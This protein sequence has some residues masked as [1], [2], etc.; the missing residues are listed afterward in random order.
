MAL[1]LVMAAVTAI[2][3][4]MATEASHFASSKGDTYVLKHILA[5]QPRLWADMLCEVLSVSLRQPEIALD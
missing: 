4:V 1:T 2:Y 3:A 5:F